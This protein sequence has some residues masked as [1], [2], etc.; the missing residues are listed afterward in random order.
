MSEASVKIYST[1]WCPACIKSKK[2]FDMKGIKYEEINVA[3][4]HE[5]RNEVMEVS[6]QRSVPV[7][8]IDKNI[9][10]GFDKTSIDRALEV[11]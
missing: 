9:I 6:G 11:R 7:I 10:V 3:D 4:R 8:C 1:S 5:D 2:Y